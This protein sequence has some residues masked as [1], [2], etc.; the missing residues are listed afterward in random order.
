MKK[1]PSYLQKIIWVLAAL[2]IVAAY[3]LSISVTKPDIGKLVTSFPKARD[4]I[5][6]LLSPDLYTRTA[7]SQKIRLVFPVPCDASVQP[8]PMADTGPRIT[9]EPAC[10]NPR[11][12]VTIKGYD[13]GKN[14][15]V[16][17]RWVLPTGQLM[18]IRALKADANGN[19]TF[20]TDVRPITE[21]ANG[22]TA[23]IEADVAQVSNRIMASQALKDVINAIIE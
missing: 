5:S 17:L 7:G 3:T 2:A 22:V 19:F 10:A 1:L 20:Q 21:T 8:I 6:Q 18:S 23:Q 13:L 11:D 16:T 4:I 12:I 9:I 15:N 14:L